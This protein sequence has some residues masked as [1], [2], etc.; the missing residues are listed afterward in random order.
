MP[1][2][3]E[4][5]QRALMLLGAG[6]CAPALA[7]WLQSCSS[8]TKQPT[9]PGGT[10]E[11]DLATV[12]ELQRVGGSVKRTFGQHNGGRAVLIIRLGEREFVV[13]SAVCTHGGCDVELPQAGRIPCLPPCGH[14]SVFAVEDGRVLEGPATMPLKRFASQYD[15]ERNVL[16]ISF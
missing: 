13:F 6:V 8:E 10:V 12:P 4:F 3:R 16:K 1:H 11:L 15:P 7:P 9:E 2:R 14:G 5:L